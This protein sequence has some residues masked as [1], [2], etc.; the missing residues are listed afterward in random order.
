MKFNKKFDPVESYEKKQNMNFAKF[1]LDASME[2]KDT[3]YPKGRV[4][5]FKLVTDCNT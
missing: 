3:V 2:L 1:N 4:H 5:L